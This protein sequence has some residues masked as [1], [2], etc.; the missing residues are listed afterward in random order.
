MVIKSV[1]DKK[2]ISGVIVTILM[3]LISILAFTILAFF[4]LRFTSDNTENID[5]S[6]KG[7]DPL[8]DVNQ[9]MSGGRS[10]EHSVIGV[11][12]PE[13]TSCTHDA[14]CSSWQECTS[15][16][17]VNIT[18]YVVPPGN[19]GVCSGGQVLFMGNCYVNRGN[20]TKCDNVS[21]EFVNILL[22][23]YYYL[24][25]DLESTGTGNC[26]NVY[27]IDGVVIDG[28]GKK[29]VGQGTSG[30]R[31]GILVFNS[32]NV[33]VLNLSV[34]NFKS[35]GIY[36]TNSKNNLFM[37]IN[38]FYNFGGIYLNYYSS[39][40]N[41]SKLVVGNNSNVGITLSGQRNNLNYLTLYNNSNG[42]RMVSSSDSLISNVISF[43][44]YDGIYLT[45]PNNPSLSFN[46]VFFNITASNNRNS[47]FY[48][49]KS[50]NN[51]FVN[52]NTNE[53][54]EG[55]YL[56]NSVN[57]TFSNIIANN[58]S[59][60]IN[61]NVSSGNNLSDV[62]A[63]GNSCGVLLSNSSNNYL[64]K[65]DSSANRKGLLS[66]VGIWLQGS[67]DNSLF[68]LSLI[69][70]QDIGLGI[71]HSRN[72]QINRVF[73]CENLAK[74]LSCSGSVSNLS[75]SLNVFAI[76]QHFQITSCGGWPVLDTDY[77][78]CSSEVSR[79]PHIY[80]PSSE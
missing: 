9:W 67:H 6:M 10:T 57:N 71:H 79:P 62:F 69:G 19:G 27:D 31:Y 22:P 32:S 30:E 1:F 39:D 8:R 2:G 43:S 17:C 14:N 15:G 24:A 26:I 74:D 7:F 4:V 77:V 35:T 20:I 41:F 68:N 23:G 46:N 56:G 48:I 63:N 58:N 64:A 50:N 59:I 54:K 51:S 52:L 3:V 49:F 29:I 28:R 45:S 55:I 34:L 36:I 66:G 60:G 80:P 40:N 61:L 25:N 44:N 75:G 12:I 76:S 38:L 37:D 13:G 53:N 72:L 70:N 42:L 16:A 5:E 65:V 78:S 11:V 33:K 73:S 18:N 21:A 47:G